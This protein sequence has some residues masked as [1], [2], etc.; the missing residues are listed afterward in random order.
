MIDAQ[1]D[2]DTLLFFVEFQTLYLAFS[3]TRET[4]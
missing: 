1:I 2:T 3:A 4:K